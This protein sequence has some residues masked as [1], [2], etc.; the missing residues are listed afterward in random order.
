MTTRK[1]VALTKYTEHKSLRKSFLTVSQCTFRLHLVHS[2]SGA[3]IARM[4]PPPQMET[5]SRETP[6]AHPHPGPLP[7]VPLCLVAGRLWVPHRSGIRCP[8]QAL[9]PPSPSV[10]WQDD[11]GSLT[12][13]GSGA[14]PGPLP[15]V[16]LRL[17][18]GRLRAPHRT[19]IGCIP[20]VATGSPH[21]TLPSRFVP[22]RCGMEAQFPSF[23]F[24]W[25][26]Q[27]AFRI[28]VP[29]LL[30]HFSHV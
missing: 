3:I 11:S 25:S 14:Y 27:T 28:L 15:T 29:C 19:G 12:G 23:S 5:R 16:P 26:R 6:T 24:L 22:C 20:P 4:S 18:A 9:C 21:S 13:V 2:Q 8:T 1:T 10:S 30:S 17:M 7:T